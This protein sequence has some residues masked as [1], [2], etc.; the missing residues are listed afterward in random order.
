MKEVKIN[1]KNS[2]GDSADKMVGVQNIK[3]KPLGV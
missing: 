2:E 1:A 3:D